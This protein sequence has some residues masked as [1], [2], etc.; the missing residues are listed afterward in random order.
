MV[1]GFL[2]QRAKTSEWYVTLK[3][4]STLDHLSL[5][6]PLRP[7]KKRVRFVHFGFSRLRVLRFKTLWLLMPNGNTTLLHFKKYPVSHDFA[8][9]SLLD[10]W[11]TAFKLQWSAFPILSEVC[12]TP[13][14]R[15]CNSPT[16]LVLIHSKDFTE[17]LIENTTLASQCKRYLTTSALSSIRNYFTSIKC[18]SASASSTVSPSDHFGMSC[19]RHSPTLRGS[20]RP[21]RKPLALADITDGWVKTWCFSENFGSVSIWLPKRGVSERANHYTQLY[22]YRTPVPAYILLPYTPHYSLIGELVTQ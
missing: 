20:R 3:W 6:R 21:L 2:L 17:E 18:I 16:F 15:R 4:S 7:T 12:P 22:T 5:A 13:S 1:Y 11:T 19:I 8:I 9:S 14:K 10:L